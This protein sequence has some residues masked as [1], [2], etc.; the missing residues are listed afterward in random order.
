MAESADGVS[1]LKT[2]RGALGLA[3]LSTG[4]SSNSNRGG[5]TGR[6]AR[7]GSSG[8]DSDRRYGLDGLDEE[9]LKA[10]MEL[11][12]FLTMDIE[13]Y[14]RR[15]TMEQAAR[16]ISLRDPSISLEEFEFVLGRYFNS[17]QLKQ[18]QKLDFSTSK[19]GVDGAAALSARIRHS[20]CCLV[21]VN[22]SDNNLGDMGTT[23]LLTAMVYAGCVATL[24]R[25]DLPKNNIT[26]SLDAI[27][28][29]GRFVQLK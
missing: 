29:L 20:T 24:E 15:K 19:L 21:H 3:A 18:L 7:T 27:T 13:T 26:M 4:R 8:E 25:L 22:V 12:N 2:S 14:E 6:T 23:K 16:S 10:S 5:Q 17:W 11:N 1:F 9:S 28:V